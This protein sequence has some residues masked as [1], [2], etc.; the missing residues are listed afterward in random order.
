MSGSG[1]LPKGLRKFMTSLTYA[2]KLRK[3]RFVH[4]R[5]PRDDEELNKFILGVA[6]ELYNADFDEWPENDE[7]LS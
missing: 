5:E 3:F 2:D 7:E 1:R 4:G 6:R